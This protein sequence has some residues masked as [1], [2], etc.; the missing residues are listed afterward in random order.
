[1]HTEHLAEGLQIFAIG[2]GGVFVNLIVVYLAIL[3][4][5]RLLQGRDAPEKTARGD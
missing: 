4:I 1:M 3:G 2:L 5:G